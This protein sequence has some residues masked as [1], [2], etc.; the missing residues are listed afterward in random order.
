MTIDLYL[1]AGHANQLFRN[2]GNANFTDISFASG[3]EDPLG[4]R[5][6]S[7]AIADFDGDGLLDIYVTSWAMNFDG[8]T[9]PVD[10]TNRLLMNRPGMGF[11]DVTLSAGVGGPAARDTLVATAFDFDSDGDSDIF[12]GNVFKDFSYAMCYRDQLYANSGLGDSF[13][14]LLVDAPLGEFGTTD[15]AIMGSD[16][17]DVNG[18]GLPDFVTSDVYD[19]VNDPFTAAGASIYLNSGDG[20]YSPDQSASLGLDY[21]VNSWNAKGLDIDNDGNQDL[22]VTAATGADDAMYFMNRGDSFAAP[23]SFANGVAGR[24]LQSADLDLDG[25]DD[26]LL[27]SHAGLPRYYRN[28]SG[29]GNNSVGIRLRGSGLN[30]T[31]AVGAEVSAVSASTFQAKWVLGQ[32][33]AHGNSSRVVNLGIGGDTAADVTVVWPDQTAQTFGPLEAGPV[34]RYFIVDQDL[35]VIPEEV[36]PTLI[37]WDPPTSRVKIQATST[38]NGVYTLRVLGAGGMR[39]APL[40]SQYEANAWFPSKPDHVTVVSTSGAEFEFAVP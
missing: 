20:T 23:K 25:D 8:S 9:G 30:N 37:R 26:L 4:R 24:S 2:D 3:I 11:R 38:Y 12:A 32:H 28:D 21:A 27:V 10:K 6:T 14:D 22:A 1:P 40:G 17:M 19:P 18:D 15:Q 34:V 35:G 36:V 31:N 39:Y 5:N 7:A 33:T 16:V 13:T 29:V